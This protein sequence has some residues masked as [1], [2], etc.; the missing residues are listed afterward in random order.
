L[1][2]LV[3]TLTF[4]AVVALPATA[5]AQPH[6]YRGTDAQVTM[7]VERT[8]VGA[9]NWSYIKRA[10]VEWAR[11]SRIRVVFVN[12]CPS[13]YYCLKFTRAARP[14]RSRAGPPSITTR[15]PTSP[16]T[17]ACT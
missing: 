3:A 1:R 4:V 12:H 9:T 5:L 14:A 8:R 10:G 7:Y 13:R 15:K 2:K 16:G 6:W 17:A 11:S